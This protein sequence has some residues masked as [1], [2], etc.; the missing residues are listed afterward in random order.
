MPRHVVLVMG[1]FIPTF[2]AE[3]G[4]APPA[5]P[6]D[7]TARFVAALAFFYLDAGVAGSNYRFGLS[8]VA[9]AFPAPVVLIGA[10]IIRVIP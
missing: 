7:N 9:V 3:Q 8:L 1:N 2:V 4:F 10:G 5:M 6:F